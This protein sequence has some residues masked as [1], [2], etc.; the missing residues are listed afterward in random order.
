MSLGGGL[1]L[2]LLM[3]SIPDITSPP[4]SLLPFQGVINGDL[5]RFIQRSQAQAG[6]PCLSE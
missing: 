2:A 5:P 6:F 4:G 1:A 3:E